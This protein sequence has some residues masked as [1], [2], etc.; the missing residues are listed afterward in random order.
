MRV[1]PEQHVLAPSRTPWSHRPHLDGLRTIAVYLVVLFH[2]D[3]EAA[4]G[5]F[6]GVDLFFVLS[7]YLVT[8][9][10]L[11]DLAANGTV[12]LTRFYSRRARRLIPAAAVV[13]VATAVAALMVLPSLDRAS[14]GGDARASSLW[15]ANWHFLQQASDYFAVDGPESPFLHF[16]SLAIEEQFYL[17]FPLVVIAIW[18]A[19]ARLGWIMAGIAVLLLGS[20]SLQILLAESDVNRAYLG[21][22][23]RVYQILAGS[24]LA[25]VF[26]RWNM[27]SAVVN[28]PVVRRFVRA[29]A[30]VSVGAMLF[31]ASSAFDVTVSQRGLVATVASLAIVVTLEV[32]GAS[33]AVRMLSIRPIRYL[34]QISY[35][36]YLWHW[37]ILV[38]ARGVVDMSPMAALLVSGVL[39]TAL[40]AL[41]A[42]IIE[43]PIRTAGVLDSRPGRV[44]LGGVATAAISGLLLAPALVDWDRRPM[45]V[46]ANSPVGS[47]ESGPVPDLDWET[48][49][50]TS[51][52]VPPC[53]DPLG[54]DCT[55]VEGDLGTILVIGDSHARMYLPAF[56]NLARDR[57]MALAID[58][59]PSCPWQDGLLAGEAGDRFSPGC[60]DRR[61]I[62]YGSRIEAID[63]DLI[64]VAGFP[65][66][67]GVGTVFTDR[68]ALGDLDTD[69]LV[70]TTT[71]ATLRA[72]AADDQTILV[73]EPV[74]VLQR[75]PLS[76]L[77][78]AADQGECAFSAVPA[79]IEELLE[80]EL[81]AE[82]DNV[83]TLDLDE[84]VC[85]IAD[86]CPAIIDGS[87]VRRDRHH[88]T[89]EFAETLT[90]QLAAI[91]AALLD[92]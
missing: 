49:A 47:A 71:E 88:L 67:I 62:T 42:E 12:R 1:E 14:L 35:G 64:I 58:F 72:L 38:I 53:D 13:V 51:P 31:V 92:D 25:T 76:C 44:M 23:T 28:R 8:N 81:A 5:G 79:G 21:T 10:L 40:A 6:V 9:V 70:A 39:G 50:R 20:L 85:P 73:V 83:E 84:A 59:A 56:S 46:S 77:S 15:Y 55:V 89:P 3:I 22:D 36:T 69:D 63:P 7:G 24:L 91:V 78:A 17:A 41:S 11:S 61:P 19:G 87:V 30:V 60:A 32:G 26:W 43:S 57:G 18:K 37:P 65:R 45:I 80:R 48:I 54:S 16:W 75:D 2:A 68:D 27:A 82:F 86:A 33:A 4:S 74:P 66:T 29:L 90:P 34:G 52:D